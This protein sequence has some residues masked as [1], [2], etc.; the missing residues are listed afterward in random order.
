VTTVPRLRA[1]TVQLPA[2]AENHVQSATA[3]ITG[4]AHQIKQ[5]RAAS[6]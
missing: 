5:L 3:E 2:P 1:R 6:L 4:L